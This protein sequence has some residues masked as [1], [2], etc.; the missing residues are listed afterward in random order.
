M[1]IFIS[2]VVGG[3]V[4]RTALVNLE[5]ENALGQFLRRL[6]LSC[7]RETTPGESLIED[8]FAQTQ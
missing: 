8:L 1:A 6:E 4:K 7:G 2:Q 3:G 5:N